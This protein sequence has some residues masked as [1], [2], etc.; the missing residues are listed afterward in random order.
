MNTK[1]KRYMQSCY[2]AYINHPNRSIYECYAKPSLLKVN[3]FWKC[4]SDEVANDGRRGDGYFVQHTDICICLYN[5]HRFC[6][7]HADPKVSNI[8]RGD[9]QMRYVDTVGLYRIYELDTKECK[10]FGRVYPTFACWYK[11]YHEDIGNMTYTENETESID[12]MVKWC[13]EYSK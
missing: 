1:T 12:E 10:Q 13:V 2:N 3:A 11:H 8:I 5:Q 4:V 9:L 6:S 7:N